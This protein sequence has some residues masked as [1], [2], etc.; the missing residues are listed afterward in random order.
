M[1]VHITLVGG[2]PAPVYNGIVAT[3]PDLVV[4]VY[5]DNKD[6]IRSLN[7]LRKEVAL[8]ED[9]LPPLDTVDPQSIRACAKALAEKYAQDNVTVNISSGL[10]SWSHLFADEMRGLPN[11]HIIYMDQNN[12]LWDYSA[13]KCYNGFEFD[14]EASFRL[15]G[16]PLIHTKRFTDYTEEDESVASKL[17]TIQ[18][19]NPKE[20]RQLLSIL[21][22]VWNNMLETQPNG[23]FELS[24]GSYVEWEKDDFVRLS[25]ANKKKGV[26]VLELESPHAVSLAFNMGWFEYKVARMLSHWK[27]AKDIR[28]NC[29]FTPSKKPNETHAAKN[30]IDIIVNTGT[31]LLFV[32]CKTKIYNSTDIDKFRTA[33]RNY[34]GQSSKALFLTDV[35]MNDLQKEKCVESQ[36]LN[37]SLLESSV[38]PNK[39]QVLFNLL[40]KELFSINA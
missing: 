2:Q 12:I 18:Y 33:V 28:L 40:N 27:Y 32:E 31:K 10:K 22:P 39:E 8:P 24:S 15:Q 35:E 5:S 36:I 1:K 30:E 11:V 37:F 25:L 26:R 20:F 21:T 34:G 13:D 4:Y 3:K 23:L 29:I 16:N 19:H 6:S 14:M 38:G 9:K 7:A 17:E